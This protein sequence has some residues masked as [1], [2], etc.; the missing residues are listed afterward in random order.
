[1]P[2]GQEQ[3]IDENIPRSGCNYCR[4]KEIVR[5]I[6]RRRMMYNEIQYQYRM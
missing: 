1:M 6:R 3:L 5:I 4:I 2:Y